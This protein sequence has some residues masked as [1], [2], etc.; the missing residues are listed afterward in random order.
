[1]VLECGDLAAAKDGLEREADEELG[2]G[3]E[4]SAEGVGGRCKNRVDAER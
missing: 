3:G 2:Y 1:M 4:E